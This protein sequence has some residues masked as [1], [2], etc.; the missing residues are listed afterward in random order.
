MMNGIVLYSPDL[1]YEIP[2]TFSIVSAGTTTC[3]GG[4]TCGWRPEDE[5]SMIDLPPETWINDKF[6]LFATRQ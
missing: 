6:C 1:N 5:Q 4:K 2:Y 3:Q